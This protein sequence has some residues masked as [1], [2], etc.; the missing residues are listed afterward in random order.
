L[1][2]KKQPKKH[3]DGFFYPIEEDLVRI[4]KAVLGKLSPE[5]MA[6]LPES[7]RKDIE[8]MAKQFKPRPKERIPEVL[9]AL[10]ELWL[11][12]PD[13]RLGQLLLNFAFRGG[14]YKEKTNYLMYEQE[15]DLTLENLK[16]AKASKL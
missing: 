14:Y 15:D 4:N 5:E 13:Q 6:K 2:V 1:T 12:D 10:K 16:S 7:I 9:D 11:L 8:Q 3:K